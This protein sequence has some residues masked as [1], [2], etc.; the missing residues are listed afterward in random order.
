[1][2]LQRICARTRKSSSLAAFYP[3]HVQA[4]ASQTRSASVPLHCLQ[5]GMSYGESA[6]EPKSPDLANHLVLLPLV[7]LVDFQA[8]VGATCTTMYFAIGTH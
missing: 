4:S 2:D 5:T 1:M 7:F 6:G 3:W 8:G